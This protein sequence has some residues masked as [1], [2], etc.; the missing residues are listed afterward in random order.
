MEEQRCTWEP[1]Q[2][3]LLLL[4]VQLHYLYLQNVVYEAF[5]V[6]S[7]TFSNSDAVNWLDLLHNFEVNYASIPK[8]TH[9]KRHSTM[10]V[11]YSPRHYTTSSV[12]FTYHS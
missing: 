2:N 5:Y 6:A 3:G 12:I 7:G 10:G 8:D 4:K 1:G 9:S 11:G